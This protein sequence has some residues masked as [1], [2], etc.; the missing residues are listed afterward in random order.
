MS[1]SIQALRERLTALN[2]KM[3]A[4]LAEK[5]DRTWTKEDQAV[6]DADS[7]EAERLQKQIA[8]HKKMLDREAEENFE[9]V[10]K[11]SPKGEKSEGRKAVEAFL[12][13]KQVDFS[14]EERAAFRNTMSTTTGS[15]GGYT[16]QPRV[17]SEFIDLLK[18]YGFMRRVADNI[19]TA[20]GVDLSYPTTDGTAEVGEIV[21]Q[22]SSAASADIVFGTRP[23]NVVKFGSKIVTI[24][25]ELLQ[26][27]TIDIIALVYKRLRDRIGRF[28]N[29]KYSVGSGT[30]EPNGLSTAASVGKVGTTGQTTTVIYDDLVD[31]VDSLDAAYLDNP[32]SDPQMPGVDPGWMFSQTMRRVVRKIKDTQGRPIWTPN[33][34]EGMT[35]AT[36]DR[37]LGYPVYINN[38][39]PTP[40]ANAK[41]M[42]FGNLH[43]YVIRDAM[44]VNLFRFDDSAFMS[45]GQVGFLGWARSGGNLMDVNAV[46]QYQHSAT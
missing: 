24:P 12:R 41:S 17:A 13:K 43:R 46:K 37:L 4:Q 11:N 7:D 10:T 44:Q 27:T 6:F 32:S 1:N 40:A 5:G 18:A 8:A 31:L 21:T 16:V 38:D 23:L 45:K 39:M 2:R 14:D 3:N 30:G 29:V 28:Q 20:D 33:Y 22:N 36:P 19:T 34:D 15:E 42:A 25:I 26:D 35:S 9:D